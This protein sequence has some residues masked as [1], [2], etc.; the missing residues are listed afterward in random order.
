MNE[1]GFRKKELGRDE[2][3]SVFVGNY[4]YC[5]GLFVILGK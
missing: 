3:V 5:S 2:T 4:F 1:R